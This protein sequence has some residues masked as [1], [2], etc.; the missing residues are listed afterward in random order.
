MSTNQLVADIENELRSLS[1]ALTD[2]REGEC[3][4][5]Y[6]Y[7]MLKFGC[8]GLQWASRY[9]DVRAPRATA[10][11][12]RLGR[13]GGYCDCEIFL[14]GYELAPE[15]WMPAQEYVEGGVTYESDPAYPDPFPACKGVPRGSTQGCALWV[16]RRRGW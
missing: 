9:R 16:P 12:Q 14:N 11:E 5:C 1:A 8:N 13:K 6:V 7:R 2:P 3:L 4:L 10:L 15:H